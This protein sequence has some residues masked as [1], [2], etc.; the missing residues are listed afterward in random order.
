MENDA[1]HDRRVAG[2]F[3]AM[4]ENEFA[5]ERSQEEAGEAMGHLTQS[6]ME[7][8]HRAM[9]EA[10]DAVAAAGLGTVRNTRNTQAGVPPH[11]QGDEGGSGSR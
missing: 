4:A 11:D 8:V 3:Q 5:S 7:S 2:E 6:A 10:S 1:P 9:Q